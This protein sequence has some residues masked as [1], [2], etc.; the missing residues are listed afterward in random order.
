V[1]AHRRRGRRAVPGRDALGRMGGGGRLRAASVCMNARY[2]FNT[3][4]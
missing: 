3:K 1:F 4:I 2:E